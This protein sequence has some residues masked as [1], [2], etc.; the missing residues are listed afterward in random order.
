VSRIVRIDLD[1]PDASAVQCVVDELRRR[2]A[3]RKADPGVYRY[4]L[5]RL[6]DLVAERTVSEQKANEI[7]A[8][9]TWAHPRAVLNAHWRLLIKDHPALGS[10]SGAFPC[11]AKPSAPTADEMLRQDPSRLAA[12]VTEMARFT[13]DLRAVAQGAIELADSAGIDE[14]L[15]DRIIVAAVRKLR[16]GKARGDSA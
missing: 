9:L 8:E 11:R 12:V 10:F 6:G 2:D 5:R 3:P 7:R 4:V 15:A 14:A 13:S 1:E 16:E